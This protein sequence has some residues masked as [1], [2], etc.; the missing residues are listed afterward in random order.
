MVPS[1]NVRDGLVGEVSQK[2]QEYSVW[3]RTDLGASIFKHY[4]P[5]DNKLLDSGILTGIFYLFIRS[6]SQLLIRTVCG[7][8]CSLPPD[9]FKCRWMG[10]CPGRGIDYEITGGTR[11]SGGPSPS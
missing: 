4:I 10:Q 1:A 6:S 8:M 9:M 5:V 7:A 3:N 11:D 2:T